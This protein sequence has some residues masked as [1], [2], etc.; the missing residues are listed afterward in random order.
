MQMQEVFVV[1]I[2]FTFHKCEAVVEVTAIENSKP[3][4]RHRGIKTRNAGLIFVINLHEGL[5]TVLDALVI[6]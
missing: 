4:V 5:E 6:I 3:P 2:V 1:A